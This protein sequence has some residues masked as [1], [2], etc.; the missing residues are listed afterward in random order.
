MFDIL[1]ELETH[2]RLLP[3]GK[4]TQLRLSEE[5]SPD[6]STVRNTFERDKASLNVSAL[7]VEA[8]REPS[9]ISVSAT[10]RYMCVHSC[11]SPWVSALLVYV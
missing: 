3:A 11:I 4:L 5:V 2:L 10:D 1:F 8:C 9:Y 7:G 6:K